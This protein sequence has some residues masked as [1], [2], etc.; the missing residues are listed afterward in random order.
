[1]RPRYSP[2]RGASTLYASSSSNVVKLNGL[3]YGITNE[4]VLRFFEGYEVKEGSLRIDSSRGSS[5]SG[6]IKFTSTKEAARAVKELDRKY[7]GNRWIS[8]QMV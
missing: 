6:Y 7:L 8:L 4:E 3:P 1:M 5:G 2:P